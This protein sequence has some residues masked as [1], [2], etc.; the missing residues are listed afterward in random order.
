MFFMFY[1][2]RIVKGCC[3]CKCLLFKIKVLRIIGIG[4]NEFNYMYNNI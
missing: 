3:K 1:V 2:V 4:L